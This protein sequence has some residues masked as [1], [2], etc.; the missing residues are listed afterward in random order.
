[1]PL[2]G[3][4]KVFKPQLRW[5]AAT[6]ALTEKFLRRSPKKGIDCSVQ[7][8]PHGSHGSMATVTIVHIPVQKREAVAEEVHTMLAPFVLRHEIVFN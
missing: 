6:R 5:D 4:G 1:M 2:T 3:V 7:V 8:G